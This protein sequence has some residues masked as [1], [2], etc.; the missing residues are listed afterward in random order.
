MPR[1][2]FSGGCSLSSSS[3]VPRSDGSC[4]IG[5]NMLTL[6][7]SFYDGSNNNFHDWPQWTAGTTYTWTISVSIAG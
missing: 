1:L 3:G 7:Y 5:T 4:S 2:S 6:N